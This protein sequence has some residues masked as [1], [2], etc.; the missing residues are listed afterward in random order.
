M[1]DGSGTKLNADADG[2]KFVGGKPRMRLLSYQSLAKIADVMEW[3]AVTKYDFHNW[4]K[5]TDPAKRAEYIDAMLRHAGAISDGQTDF[6]KLEF[7]T[8]PESGKTH[9]AHLGACVM[10]MLHWQAED[11]CRAKNETQK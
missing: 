9:L 10:I 6:Y 11:E 5:I 1:T 3:A 7:P 4:K 8:D 2:T